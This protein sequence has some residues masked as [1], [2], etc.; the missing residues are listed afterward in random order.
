MRDGILWLVLLLL[1]LVEVSLM[2]FVVEEESRCTPR[3]QNIA[4]RDYASRTRSLPLPLPLSSYYDEASDM[5]PQRMK[6]ARVTEFNKPC[7]LTLRL[8][9]LAD[10]MRRRD[11]RN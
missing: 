10:M 4:S 7:P 9:N 3:I 2:H 6:A 5:A 11:P 1:L 8:R